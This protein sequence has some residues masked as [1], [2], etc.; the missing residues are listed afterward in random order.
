MS[1]VLFLTSAIA[2]LTL[3]YYYWVYLLSSV[4]NIDNFFLNIFFSKNKSYIHTNTDSDRFE[5]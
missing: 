4:Y 5:G 1:L 2:T 3:Q